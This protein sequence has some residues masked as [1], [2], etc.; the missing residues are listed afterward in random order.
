MKEVNGFVIKHIQEM[1]DHRSET[2]G[3]VLPQ[4][5]I[6]QAI[7]RDELFILKKA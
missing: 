1:A 6:Q 5:L 7:E 3:R 4:P 2:F